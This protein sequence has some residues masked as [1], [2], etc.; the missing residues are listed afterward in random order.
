MVWLVEWKVFKFFIIA[1]VIANSIILATHSYEYR[2]DTTYNHRTT[3]EDISS[4]AFMVIFLLEFIFKVIAMGFVVNKNSYIRNGWNILDFICL[5][6]AI[7][8]QIFTDVDGFMMLRML[9]VLKPFRSIK[10]VPSLQL[11]VQSLFASFRGLLNIYI[12]LGIVLSFFAIFG[13]NM[14][15][16]KHYQTCRSTPELIYI[17]D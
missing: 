6:T 10:A 15:G 1:A 4:K 16:G 14:F 8:E 7:L 3:F 11:L 9:R 17:P 2:L 12:F 13:V 5:V